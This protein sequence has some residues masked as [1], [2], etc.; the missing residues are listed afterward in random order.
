MPTPAVNAFPQ[1]PEFI[2]QFR[3]D[4]NN[5]AP[6]LGV[7]YD[8]FGNGR[9]VL[10]GGTGE[11]FGYMPDILLSNPLTQ[12]SGNFS[13]VTITCTA[14]P[15]VPCPAFPNLLSPAQ[16][17]Q[18][19]KISTDIVTVDPNYQAQQAWRSSVQFE[20]QIGS[21]Y[22]AAIGGIYSKMTNVQGSRNINAVPTGVVLG[23]LP[24]YDL[25]NPN[26]LY[27]DMGVVRQLCSCETASF[28]ALTLETHRLAVRGSNLSWDVSYTWSRSIDEDTNERSTSTS[29]LFDPNNPALSQGP[30][31]N[32]VPHRV[33]G[34]F[35][36]RL[37][38][39][40]MV[41]GIF[42]WRSGVPYNG[43][44]AFTGVG[45][46]GSPSSLNG[47][48][49][50]T[51]N[52]PIFVDA[53]GNTI[54]LTQANGFSRQQF[55]AFLA[56]QGGHLIGRNAFRQPNWHDL[57]LR[58]AKTVD[59]TPRVHVQIFAEVFNVLNT[60]NQVVGSSNQNL[61]LAKY[62]QATDKYTFTKFT[63]FGLNSS[64]ATTPDPRQFQVA[65]KFIF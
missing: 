45:I 41:S 58:L 28:K 49:Q 26:R 42:Q 59:L 63:T 15:I 1:H 33:V 44:I 30:S 55:A 24:L 51:G 34:D 3:E 22:T 23:N 20:Q 10:R 32:D 12:I 47:L 64:Y 9:T 52:I 48:S 53:G 65:A 5:V 8:L 39:Q 18:L 7:A 61:F 2:T 60:Q 35:V 38:W 13:Q 29:F 4:K 25:V 17:N 31:D 27:T 21:S 56:G 57:D 11:F 37:P 62:T 46:P 43:G 6:R 19:A 16:F 14:A 54:D 50:T 40:L 36:Y